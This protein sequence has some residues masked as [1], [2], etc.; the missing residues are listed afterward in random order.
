M[1]ALLDELLRRQERLRLE[2]RHAHERDPLA[3]VQRP[4]CPRK[5]VAPRP[6]DRPEL[7]VREPGLLAELAPECL[8]EFLA[9][10]DA[11][12]GR[13]PELLTVLRVDEA[14]E[15]DAV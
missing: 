8:F 14:D 2:R 5:D 11:A 9:R 1:D 3:L 10:V 15:Q 4:T 7:D 6:D 13:R 12:A